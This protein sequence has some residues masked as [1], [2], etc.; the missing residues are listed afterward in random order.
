MSEFELTYRQGPLASGTCLK[1]PLTLALLW[2]SLDILSFHAI[3]L[4]AA[5]PVYR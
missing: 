2:H 5:R 4:S 3:W 1:Q